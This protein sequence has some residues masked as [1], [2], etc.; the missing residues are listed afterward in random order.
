MKTNLHTILMF[1]FLAA[2]LTLNSCGGFFGIDITDQSS[3]DSNLRSKIGEIITNDPGII[4]ISF[5]LSDGSTFSKTITGASVHYFEPETDNVKCK[6][7]TLSGKTEGKDKR[8]SHEYDG[9]M[10]FNKNYAVITPSDVKNS[11]K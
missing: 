3:I 1:I 4:E 11:A 6:W 9:T 2:A 8:V 7:I 5:S 10:K